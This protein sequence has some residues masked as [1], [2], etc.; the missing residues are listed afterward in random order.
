[1]H[2]VIRFSV[3]LSLA[4]SA[5]SMSGCAA[6]LAGMSRGNSGGGSSASS[7]SSTA[8]SRATSFDVTTP[9]DQLASAWRSAPEGQV[10]GGAS[11]QSERNFATRA[12]ECN[13]SELL[14]GG[15][16]AGPGG[17][18][19]GAH[20][21][22]IEQSGIALKPAFVAWLSSRGT[23]EIGGNIYYREDEL[24]KSIKETMYWL[25]TAGYREFAEPLRTLAMAQSN[26]RAQAAFL[27]YF[28]EFDMPQ[29]EAL[30][31]GLLSNSAPETRARACVGMKYFG[32]S[33]SLRLVE[34]VAASDG[35]SEVQEVRGPSGAMYAQRVFPIRE[36]CT[37]AATA[38]QTSG[39]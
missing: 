2:K 36:K 3:L 37:E 35:Y 1:M 22:Q 4:F 27:E 11:L 16:M 20:L 29:G 25:T 6:I 13:N 30:A 38:I 28:I 31:A 23:G 10:T 39:R 9:C 19:N 18:A 7:T 24:H 8:S 15:F 12:L 34:G 26:A 32:S 17:R 21:R 14:F 5:L 33:S